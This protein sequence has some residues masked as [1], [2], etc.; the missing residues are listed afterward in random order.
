MSKRMITSVVYVIVLI[1]LVALKWLVPNNFGAIGFDVLFTAVSVIGT[2]ELLRAVGCVC[3][4]QRAVAYVY[5][6]ALVPFYSIACFLCDN[7]VIDI[8][9]FAS[10]AAAFIS[11]IA[12]M[13]AAIL[14]VFDHENCSLKSTAYCLFS[15]VYC[16]F[17]PLTMSAVNHLPYNSTF[18]VLFLFI[19]TVFTDSGAFIF[20]V[21]LHGVFPKKMAP[22]IS[23]NKTVIGGI[24]GIVGAVVGAVA[25]YFLYYLLGGEFIYSGNLPL[26]LVLCLFSLF[27]GVVVQTGDLFESAIKRECGIKDMGNI[28]PGHGGMLDRF[29]SMLFTAPVVLLVF[30]VIA[31]L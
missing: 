7:G 30:A 2:F 20:G 27:L 26:L 15:L 21:L 1:A 18:A 10:S 25:S 9:Y 5:S 28:L 23:P 19:V 16:G 29:D 24:G 17:L 31:V 6:A 11:G 12:V 14:L 13:A 22:H 8:P 4:S 3:R